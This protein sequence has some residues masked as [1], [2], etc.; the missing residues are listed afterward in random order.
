MRAYCAINTLLQGGTDESVNKLL[1]EMHYIPAGPESYVQLPRDG[2]VAYATQESWV[3]NATI[4]VS[5]DSN[6]PRVQILIRCMCQDNIV[7]GA[8]FDETRY[9]AVLDQ[10][11]LKRDLELFEAGDLTEVGEKGVTLRYVGCLRKE[12]TSN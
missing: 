6:I 4:R 2:G 11:A 9:D 8:P 1:G 5:Y 12:G 7:F 3:L 10:C